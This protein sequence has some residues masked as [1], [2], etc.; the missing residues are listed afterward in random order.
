MINKDELL[1][2]NKSLKN[3]LE[4]K[5]VL[6]LNP[7]L[8][9]YEEAAEILN[10]DLSAIYDVENRLDKFAPLIKILFPEIK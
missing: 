5:E 6:W 3:V 7:K 2:S 9:Q 1:N 8:T 10:V 4:L